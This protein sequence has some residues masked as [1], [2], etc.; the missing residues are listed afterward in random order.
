MWLSIVMV[1]GLVGFAYLYLDSLFCDFAD[2]F[3]GE[4]RE[5]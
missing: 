1:I 2:D 5:K 3:F 4:T